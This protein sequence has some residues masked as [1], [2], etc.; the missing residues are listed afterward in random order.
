MSTIDLS[1][2]V[3]K[4]PVITVSVFLTDQEVKE[5]KQRLADLRP[6]LQKHR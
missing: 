4:V 1:G 3:F 6:S 5:V 2:L